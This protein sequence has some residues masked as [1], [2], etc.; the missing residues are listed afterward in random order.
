LFIDKT[1]YIKYHHIVYSKT[2]GA[3]NLKRADIIIVLIIAAVAAAG[4]AV[5]KIAGMESGKKYVEITVEG[6]LYKKVE[7]TKGYSERVK[8]ETDHG[9]NIIYIHD[10]GVQIVE[11]DCRDHICVDTG[12]IDKNGQ[13]IVCLPHK[14][15]VKIVSGNEKDKDEIDA[16]SQ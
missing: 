12:F 3:E 8:V 15:Y 10:G 2:V 5:T 6:R 11:S 13:M 9:H 14:L 4:M 7:L 1:E 16:V